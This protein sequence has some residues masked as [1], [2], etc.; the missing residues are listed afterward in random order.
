LIT[1]R[2]TSLKTSNPVSKVPAG[3]NAD[4]LLLL[5]HY[6]FSSSLETSKELLSLETINYFQQTL[7]VSRTSWKLVTRSNFQEKKK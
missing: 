6:Y 7:L 4:Q 1:A 3:L 2:K 5:V